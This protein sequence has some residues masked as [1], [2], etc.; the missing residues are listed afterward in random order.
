MCPSSH[1]N[2]KTIKARVTKFG[3]F[4]AN[5]VVTLILSLKGQR[6]GVTWPE[7]AEC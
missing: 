6:F 3:A 5:L 1:S 2:S 7:N 4:S